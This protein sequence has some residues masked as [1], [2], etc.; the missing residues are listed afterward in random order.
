VSY[1]YGGELREQNIGVTCTPCHFGGRRVWFV[2]PGCQRRCAILFAGYMFACKGC[3]RL[4]YES[5][6]SGRAWTGFNTMRRIRKQL[7]AY[8]TADVWQPIPKRPR[9]MWQRR[10][11]R[12]VAAYERA[13]ARQ[14]RVDLPPVQAWR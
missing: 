2:C 4:K 9:G 5:Q 14:S 8:P 1:R 10:Y 13:R 11:D 3:H 7:G 6:R 12:I